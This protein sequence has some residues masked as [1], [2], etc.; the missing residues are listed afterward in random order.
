MK[1]TIVFISAL[2]FLASVTF[3]QTPQTQDKTKTST[4]T[5]C[6]M[7]KDCKSSCKDTKDPKGCCNHS[8]TGAKPADNT[9]ATDAKKTETTPEKK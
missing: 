5:D 4:K 6:P 2:F 8:T 7:K 3:A 9:K 1:K